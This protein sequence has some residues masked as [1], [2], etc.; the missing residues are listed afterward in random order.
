MRFLLRRL[1][2]LVVVLFAVTLLTFLLVNVLPG[3]VAYDIAGQDASEE[4]VQQIREDLGLSEPVL[5]RYANWLGNFLIGD[6]G[7][8]Y[9]TGEPVTEAIFS[10]F[11]VSLELMILAQL[12]AVAL[13]LPFG[14]VSAYR[15]GGRLDRWIA[16]GAFLS[17]S[18][19]PFMVA[20]LLIFLFKLYI[21]VL[22]ATGYAPLSEGL[23]ENLRYFILP[24]TGYAPLSEGFWQ[25][26]RYFILPALSFALAEWTVLMRVLRADMIGVLQQDYIAMA[27][28]K[29]LPT[30]RIILVHALR[31]SSFSMITIL[32]LQV[33]SLIGGSIIIES[34]FALPGVGRLL[35]NAIYSR[36]FIVIQGAV[37][38]IAVAYVM[39]NF[40]VDMLY[41]V[42]DPRIRVEAAHG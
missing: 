36:D 33:G 15:S 8:S 12:F 16:G 41:A 24:A 25:N 18:M 35:V 13:A 32:G 1:P 17:L 7:E 40:A 3:D 37:T 31:P 9:I 21:Q 30:L 27:R 4:E 28:A 23:W 11:P 6:W 14:I 19:P 20:I 38:F 5:V 26:L 22:P 42:L 10:R 2:R 34:I 29:G 39:I